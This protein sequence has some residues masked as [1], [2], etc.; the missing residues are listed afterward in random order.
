VQSLVVLGDFHVGF[1]F[2]TGTPK[3]LFIYIYICVEPLITVRSG[4]IEYCLHYVWYMYHVVNV[5]MSVR[6]CPEFRL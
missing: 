6:L 1:V 4:F 5:I 2:G 3:Y